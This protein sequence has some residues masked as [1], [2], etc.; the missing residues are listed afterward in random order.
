MYETQFFSE[1]NEK[2]IDS[3]AVEKIETSTPE[4]GVGVEKK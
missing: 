2:I 4:S 1:N 3:P